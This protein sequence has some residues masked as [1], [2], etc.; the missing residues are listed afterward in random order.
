MWL[1][2]HPSRWDP[3]HHHHRSRPG[4]TTSWPW[5]PPTPRAQ[6]FIRT[7][8][9]LIGNNVSVAVKGH[10]R[11]YVYINIHTF[12][13]YIYNYIM[14]IHKNIYVGIKWYKATNNTTHILLAIPWS[15]VFWW[16]WTYHSRRLRY[17]D[18]RDTNGRH[19]CL[20]FLTSTSMVL[21]TCQ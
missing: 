11:T 17:G 1:A 19:I 3:G 10:H 20:L 12:I 21:G 13:L 2:H 7:V 8:A 6:W 16:G 15:Y 9:C 14:Y 18:N 4:R 5:R